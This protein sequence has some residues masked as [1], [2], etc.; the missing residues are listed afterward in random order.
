VL[1]LGTDIII[2]LRIYSLTE[3]TTSWT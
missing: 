1:K 3:D 2:G